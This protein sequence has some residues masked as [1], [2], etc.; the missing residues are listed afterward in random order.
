MKSIIDS[1]H[2]IFTCPFGKYP[3]PHNENL[4]AIPIIHQVVNLLQTGGR[5]P[6]LTLWDMYMIGDFQSPVD[7]QAF[8]IQTCTNGSRL[9]ASGQ[10]PYW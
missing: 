9:H 8:L 5:L 4:A 1:L 6:Y 10:L 3:V 7:E 2:S